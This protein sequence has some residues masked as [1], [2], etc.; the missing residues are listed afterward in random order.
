MM[1]NIDDESSNNNVTEYDGLS[2]DK[3]DDKD[4]G[5]NVLS[6]SSRTSVIN[7]RWLNQAFF[8]QS[9]DNRQ[10]FIA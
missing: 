5:I 6:N 7:G 2:D 1:I 9:T 4:S 3:S 10:S 8:Y